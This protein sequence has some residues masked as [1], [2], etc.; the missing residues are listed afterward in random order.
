M[1]KM[2]DLNDKTIGDLRKEPDWILHID[3]VKAVGINRVMDGDDD[4]F[5]IVFVDNSNT[6]YF[7]NNTWNSRNEEHENLISF[8]FEFQ[9]NW[10]EVVDTNQILYPV[11]LKGRPIFKKW[12]SNFKTLFFELKRVLRINTHI[13]SGILTEE[14]ERLRL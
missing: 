6:L 9:F 5:F 13:A 11:E 3:D 7:I 1:D 8:V 4:S 2:N 12:S 14:V 10:G